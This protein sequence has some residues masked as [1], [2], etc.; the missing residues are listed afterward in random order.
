MNVIGER[1]QSSARGADG[2]KAEG[3][4]TFDDRL[5]LSARDLRKALGEIHD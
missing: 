2:A 4:T 5:L 3:D 1:A